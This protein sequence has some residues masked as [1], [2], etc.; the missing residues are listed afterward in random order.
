MQEHHR[1]R[2]VRA[3]ESE[4]TDLFRRGALKRQAR[5]MTLKHVNMSSWT[6]QNKGLNL[7]MS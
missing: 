7:M 4:Q 5:N 6:P 3:D 1:L 2:P